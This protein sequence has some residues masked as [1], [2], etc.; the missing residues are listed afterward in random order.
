MPKLGLES[1][2]VMTLELVESLQLQERE[3]RLA[4]MLEQAHLLRE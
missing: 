4:L 2:Q 3:L 1:L